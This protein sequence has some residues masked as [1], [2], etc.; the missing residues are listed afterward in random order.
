MHRAPA[1]RPNK[2]KCYW[3]VD[4]GPGGAKRVTRFRLSRFSNAVSSRASGVVTPRTRIPRLL[5]RPCSQ[6]AARH[7]RCRRSRQTSSHPGSTSAGVG[8]GGVSRH[9]VARALVAV[10]GSHD[11]RAGVGLAICGTSHAR[12]C[13]P[14]QGTG[15][16]EGEGRDGGGDKVGG[17]VP[18]AG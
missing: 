12:C 11:E 17:R 2:R 1:R 5:L 8:I 10:A 16:A 13:V 3:H 15:T 4:H 6:R 18:C 9:A 14:V 7:R